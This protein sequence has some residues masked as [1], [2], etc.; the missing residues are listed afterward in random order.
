MRRETVNCAV[1]GG[2]FPGQEKGGGQNPLDES[3]RTKVMN[4]FLKKE[5]KTTTTYVKEKKT[6]LRAT[7]G[8][9]GTIRLWG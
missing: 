1:L 3:G 9:K 4:V 2:Y 6:S 8:G 7:R 5:K